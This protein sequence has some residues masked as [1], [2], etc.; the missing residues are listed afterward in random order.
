VAAAKIN[1]KEQALVK[2]TKQSSQAN[3]TV[4]MTRQAG[5]YGRQAYLL[6]FVPNASDF[7][8]KWILY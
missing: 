7:S 4:R 6:C 3:N 8:S 1:F 2:G 5:H